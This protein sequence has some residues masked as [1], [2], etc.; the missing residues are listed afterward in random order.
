MNTAFYK[1]SIEKTYT[2]HLDNIDTLRELPIYNELNFVKT[3]NA[4]KGYARSYN[5]EVIN[6]KDPPIQLTIS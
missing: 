2:K 4:F 3:S 6:L 5:V 1:T